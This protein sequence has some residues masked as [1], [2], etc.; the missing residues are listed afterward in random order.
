MKMPT[1]HHV[2]LGFTDQPFQPGTH[3]C[4][5]YNSEKE[6][7]A[8]LAKFLKA[9]LEG[10]ERCGYFADVIDEK[11][12][13]DC[14]GD[15]GTDLRILRDEGKLVLGTAERMYC[16]DGFFDGNR[17]LQSIREFHKQSCECGF[18][19]VRISGEMGWATRDI[20]R[21]DELVDYE[22]RVTKVLEELPVT[23]ICQYDA[24]K[25]DGSLLLDIIQVHPLLLVRGQVV[26]NPYYVAEGTAQSPLEATV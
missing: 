1:G 11:D 8:V 9:G 13:W 5:V 2:S 4:F 18:C 6:R 12:L 23:A 7:K 19:G 15:L 20:S 22:Y 14:L 10:G 25:F 16:P 17:M 24:N 21:R 3:M 26:H